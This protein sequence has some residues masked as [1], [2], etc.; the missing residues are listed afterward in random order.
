LLS[1]HFPSTFTKVTRSKKMPGG[2]V[3]G[4][5][6]VSANRADDR[7]FESRQGVRFLGLCMYSAM[8]SLQRNS[9]CYCVCV[10]LSDKLV[11]NILYI[12][13]FIYKNN[14]HGDISF[15]RI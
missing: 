14:F 10:F 13:K 6:I 9:H 4:V 1:S 2:V 3:Y 8:L 12:Y 15:P 11:K 7:G 5:V